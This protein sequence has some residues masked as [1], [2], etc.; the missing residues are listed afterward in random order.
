MRKLNREKTG[1]NIK[2]IAKEKHIC[3]NRIAERCGLLDERSVSAWYSNRSFPRL[4]VLVI[5]AD[6]LGVTIDNLLVCDEN[7]DNQQNEDRSQD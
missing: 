5:L 3:A 4:Q 1:Q 6:M 2:R 7:T